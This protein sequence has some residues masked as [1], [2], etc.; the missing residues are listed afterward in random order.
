MDSVHSRAPHPG[1][2][3]TITNMQSDESDKSDDGSERTEPPREVGPTGQTR[4]EAPLG[5]APAAAQDWL[6]LQ[7][8]LA[9]QPEAIGDRL[10]AGS[11][12]KRILSDLGAQIELLPRQADL[13]DERAAIANRNAKLEGLGIRVVPLTNPA[14]PSPLAAL[15]DAPLVLLV[16]G[17]VCALS[18]PG[19]S[20][21]GARAA[22]HAARGTA[23]RL[24]REL[25]AVGFTIVSGLARGIDAEAHRG[26][27]EAHGRTVGVLACGP[28]RIYPPE[29]RALAEE[30][31]ESGAVISEMP[32]GAPPRRSHFPLRNRIISG[33]CLAVIVVE[34]RKRSGSLITVRHALNQGREVFVVPG[35]IEGP[36]AEGTNQL[37][38]DGAR[39]IR[40][41]R[42]VIEDLGMDGRLD[43]DFAIPAPTTSARATSP[44][45]LEA[46]VLAV[47]ALGPATRDELLCRAELDASGLASVLLELE[48]TGRIVEDR[49]G[50]IHARWS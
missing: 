27:L 48:L 37:L 3:E 29:H 31:L 8:A 32:L 2:R 1:P 15:I 47:L 20:I 40:C 35:S 13:V 39:P 49:D 10:R 33:L 36:F 50:R 6:E 23:R 5:L 9:L 25:A 7:S 41:A 28:D 34:A 24:A 18:S 17:R 14:Y 46:R 21:V 26:A 44:D 12:P 43:F 22:T 4:E 45:S 11:S 38:R 19:I 30:I 16:R 42:D